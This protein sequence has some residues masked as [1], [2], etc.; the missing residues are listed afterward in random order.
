VKR[1][2]FLVSLSLL[3][4]APFAARAQGN[5]S[6]DDEAAESAQGES[7]EYEHAITSALEEYRLGHYE[8]ARSLFQKAQDLA[9]SA[10]TLRGLG[11]VEFE[12]RHYVRAAEL[13]NASLEDE[14]KPLTMA[15]RSSVNELLQRT[16][17]FIAQYNLDVSPDD[18]PLT[19]QLDGKTV[20]VGEERRL[21]LEAGEHTL[22]ISAPN[23]EPREL[24]IDVKGG[25]QQTLRIELAVNPPSHAAS[26]DTAAASESH[27]APEKHPRRRRAAI[28]LACVGGAL[29]ITGGVMGGLALGSAGDAQT[30]HDSDADRARTLALT[31]DV[32]IGVGVSSLVAGF[33]LWLVERRKGLP[34]DARSTARWRQ[35]LAPPQST[36]L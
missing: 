14:R 8:E 31:A 5:R 12:L 21:S 11:M 18:V 1:L 29:A 23:T 30:S 28:A 20:R 32:S 16:R 27:G 13:L 2:A 26:V 4:A 25:E 6:A 7:T 22:R 24:Y 35:W 19:I 36:H 10:R 15:Q 9:P 33:A 34:H 3:S 17:Q